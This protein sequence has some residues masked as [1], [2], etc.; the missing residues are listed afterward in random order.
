MKVALLAEVKT[1]NS[2]LFRI[3]VDTGAPLLEIL[4]SDKVDDGFS[5]R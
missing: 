3:R 2:Y 1:F 4:E 5:F